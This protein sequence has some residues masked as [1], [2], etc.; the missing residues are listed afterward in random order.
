MVG[1]EH[2]VCVPVDLTDHA[3]PLTLGFPLR[4]TTCSSQS[5]DQGAS[6]PL[7]HS[8]VLCAQLTGIQPVTLA[9]SLR[10]PTQ[11]CLVFVHQEPDILADRNSLFS[12]EPALGR[13]NGGI[14]AYKNTHTQITLTLCALVK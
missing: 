13:V 7:G 3:G 2:L 10:V 6:V 5:D 11:F 4:S 1:P 8:C 14:T 12:A 9:P